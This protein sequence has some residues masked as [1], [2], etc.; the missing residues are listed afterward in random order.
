MDFILR[1]VQSRAIKVVA[2]VFLL[3]L[4]FA[5]TLYLLLPGGGKF[6][7]QT[8]GRPPEPAP[9]EAESSP[10]SISPTPTT[11]SRTEA[12]P[13]ALPERS[14]IIL[15]IQLA[16][17]SPEEYAKITDAARSLGYAVRSAPPASESID[18][19]IIKY[20]PGYKSSAERLAEEIRSS[21]QLVE[22][23]LSGVDLWLILGRS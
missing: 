3:A 1:I 21:A 9:T 12:T 16:G 23:P 11:T 10:I 17:A 2:L 4:A 7:V 6:V 8:G 18:R 15:V 14:K 20:R 5:G 22:E 13:T 19:S